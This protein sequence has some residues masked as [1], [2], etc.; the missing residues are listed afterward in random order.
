MGG[1]SQ[2][3]V[4]ART[5]LILWAVAALVVVVLAVV[6]AA[7]QVLLL[8][9]AGVL[10]G[11]SLRG[12]ALV[13]SRTFHWPVGWSLAGCLVALAALIVGVGFWIGPNIANQ[14]A[15]LAEELEN[16]YRSLQDNAPG[17]ADS[18][19][20]VTSSVAEQA[21]QYAVKAAGLLASALGVIGSMVFVFFIAIYLA[22][23]PGQYS[24]GVVR[25]VPPSRRQEAGDLLE[26]LATT[27]RRWLLGRLVSMTA[28][29]LATTLGLWALGIPLPVTLGLLAGLL[30]F[31]PNIGP[32]VSAVPAVLLALTVS[33]W[34][35][36][37]VG[38]L[39]MGVNLADGYLLTP[40]VQKRAVSLPPALILIAQVVFGAL[41]GVLGVMLATPIMACLIVLV[42]RLYVEGAL[43]KP[44]RGA[45]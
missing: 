17:I 3:S 10:L 37:Y 27:L 7:A 13:V 9:F 12:L 15:V 25:L 11:T 18:V 30:G 35:G 44:P 22:V 45:A 4:S 21:G 24:Q 20:G 32:L 41:W 1:N 34:H 31:V 33:L 23:G 28:V 42:R 38:I 5:A 8:T 40:W 14:G 16:A 43:E 39:Y 6:H 19:F 29:G 26:S 2:S 36:V